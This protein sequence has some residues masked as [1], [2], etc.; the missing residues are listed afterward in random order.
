MNI[1]LLSSEIDPASTNIKEH[2]LNK[3]YF[4]KTDETFEENK[5]LVA[6]INNRILRLLNCKKDHIFMENFDKGLNTD[7]IVVLSKHRAASGKPSLSGHFVGNYGL[8]EYGG[9][10]KVL[11]KSH[12]YFLKNYLINLNEITNDPNYEIT[13][14][15]THHGPYVETPLIYIEIGSSEK[16]WKD[17]N[18]AEIV[19]ESLIKTLNSDFGDTKVAIGFGGTHYCS[20]FNKI[21]FYSEYALSHICP[22]H[23]IDNL[24]EDL[25]I[26]M[27]RKSNNRAK[28]AI[29][30]WKGLDS[31]KR[32]KIIA[33]LDKLNIP[34]KKT[35]DI[36]C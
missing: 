4:E 17:P 32:N 7:L 21:E 26:Q 36:H 15:S 10:E 9:K 30:D 23:F 2:I 18:A 6:K 11:C 28:L 34:W 19:S 22:K 20:N 3:I 8:A 5:I 29:L 33:I 24:N 14:E 12:P 16:Q 1:I 27:I 13:L 35:K 31:P 25:V